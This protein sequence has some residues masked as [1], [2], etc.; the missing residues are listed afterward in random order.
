MMVLYRSINILFYIIEILIIVRAFMSFIPSLRGSFLSNFIYEMTEPILG[1]CR[2][3][4]ERAGLN[5]MMIDFSPIL[6]IIFLRLVS[7][8]LIAII[9]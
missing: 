5:T 6:A 1:P 7:Y 3:L 8:F 9:F 2:G 4:L